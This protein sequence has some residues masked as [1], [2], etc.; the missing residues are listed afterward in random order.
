MGRELQI[1]TPIDEGPIPSYKRHGRHSLKLEIP[2]S[3]NQRIV[4]TADKIK[5]SLFQEGAKFRYTTVE[6]V[7][8]P[9]YK[10]EW[11]SNSFLSQV[12]SYDELNTFCKNAA[13][14]CKE[15]IK[16]ASKYKIISFFATFFAFLSFALSCLAFIELYYLAVAAPIV[17]LVWLVEWYFSRKLYKKIQNVYKELCLYIH[18]NKEPLVSKGVLPRPG[19]YGAFIEFVPT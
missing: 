4:A 10:L 13:K 9:S 7:S 5:R 19:Q 12:C 8:K 18:L 17:G 14:H 16:Q 2:S 6:V 3:N 11:V 1:E 15:S